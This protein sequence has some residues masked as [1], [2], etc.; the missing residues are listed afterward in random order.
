MINLPRAKFADF[1]SAHIGAGLETGRP[2]WRRP[3]LAYGTQ[4]ASANKFT[5]GDY[6]VIPKRYRWF[7]H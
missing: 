4:G 3:A 1:Q 7:E 5:R 2:A 6:P